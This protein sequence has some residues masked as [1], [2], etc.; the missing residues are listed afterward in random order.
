MANSFTSPQALT[1]KDIYIDGLGSLHQFVLSLQ[2]KCPCK[3]ITIFLY[4]ELGSGKTTFTRTWLRN[5]GYIDKVPSPS[6]GLVQSYDIDG[7]YYHHFDCYRTKSVKQLINMDVDYYLDGTATLLVEW[8]QHG[9]EQ[10]CE[11]DLSIHFLLVA[12]KP[13]ARKLSIQSHNPQI[14]IEDI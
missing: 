10:L 6:F 7:R 13:E 14:R 4:G 8:P 12:D 9:M 11:P 1:K 2:R 3:P 5:C